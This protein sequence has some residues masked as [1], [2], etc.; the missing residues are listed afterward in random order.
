MHIH[1]HLHEQLCWCGL[2]NPLMQ[3]N[4]QVVSP[5]IVRGYTTQPSIPFKADMHVLPTHALH[6]STNVCGPCTAPDK[7]GDS[8]L[9]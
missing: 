3:V 8:D 9:P 6:L 1:M 7:H 5:V 4:E 2:R